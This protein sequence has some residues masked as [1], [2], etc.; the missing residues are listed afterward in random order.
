MIKNIKRKT[1]YLIKT[2]PGALELLPRYKKVAEFDNGDSV[3]FLNKDHWQK[4]M[5]EPLKETTQSWE[6]RVAEKFVNNLEI[7][8]RNLQDLDL[9]IDELSEEEKSRMLVVV[10]D[11]FKTLQAIRALGDKR[12]LDF[13]GALEENQGD[14]I[15]PHASSCYYHDEIL[16]LAI[17][18]SIRYDDDSHA[19][20][21]TEERVQ[22]LVSWFFDESTNFDY[23]IPGNSIKRVKDMR[24]I[25]KK[26]QTYHKI[27]KE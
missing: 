18:G 13:R 2:F 24:K 22:L 19:F 3:D 14:G 15:V 21:M 9:W 10:R 1:R 20:F 17:E 25:S 6:A 12:N 11:E 16:T 27:T 5:L 23:R 26:G 4:N 8:K 7:A